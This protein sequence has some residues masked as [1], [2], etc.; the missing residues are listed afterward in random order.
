ME[1]NPVS[2]QPADGA[3]VPRILPLFNRVQHLYIKQFRVW[4]AIT[5][6]TSLIATLILVLSDRKIREISRYIPWYELSKRPFEL[7]EIYL[8]RFGSFFFVWFLGCFVLGAIATKVGGLDR[9]DEEL[10]LRDSHQLAREHL[11]EILQI[12]LLTFIA[13]VLGMMLSENVYSA[14]LKVVGRARFSPYIFAASLLQWVIV[15]S[16]VSWLGMAIPYVVRG[17]GFWAAVKKSLEA[18]DGYQG[19]LL[20]LVLQS[21]VVSYVAWYVTQYALFYLLPAFIRGT[22]WYGW[23]ALIA[24]ALASAAVEPPIFIGFS[25]LAEQSARGTDLSEIPVSR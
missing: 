12:A 22:S 13:F 1:T 15:A 2:L 24:S 3:E 11:L 14:I 21:L 4:F 17:I 25:L 16:I 5:A 23:V 7:A 20:L 18:A 6:P 9:D 8:L 19:F 10:A